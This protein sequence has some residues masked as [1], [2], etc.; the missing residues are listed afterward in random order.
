MKSSK[1]TLLPLLAILLKMMERSLFRRKV[2]D[3]MFRKRTKSSIS[4]Y[5]FLSQSMRA[6][7]SPSRYRSSRL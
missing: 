3:S 1:S 2:P 6:L 4:M 7:V 5:P